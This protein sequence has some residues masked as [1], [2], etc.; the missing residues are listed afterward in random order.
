[1]GVGGSGSGRES[2]PGVAEGLEAGEKLRVGFAEFRRGE[3]K[4]P[5]PGALKSEIPPKGRKNAK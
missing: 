4:N 5:R 3:F 2:K 1:M